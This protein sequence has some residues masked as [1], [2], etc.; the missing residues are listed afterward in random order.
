MSWKAIWFLDIHDF[1]AILG[2]NLLAT[3][4]A[5]VD[6]FRKEILFRSSNQL[7]I[8]FYGE[9]QIL[10]N[11]LVFF[12]NVKQM[13]RKSYK[14][15]LAYVIDTWVSEVKLEDIPIVQEFSYVFPNDLSG[16]LPHHEVEFTID[17]I[18]STNQ[19]IASTI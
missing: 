3:Y 4:H 2:M 17:I 11:F 5:S 1:D 13:L 8:T 15:Y 14:S 12:L 6:C 7:E 18:P 9:G 10:P 19:Y 16:L